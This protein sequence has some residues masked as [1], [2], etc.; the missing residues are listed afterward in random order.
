MSHNKQFTAITTRK[1]FKIATMKND[2]VN[3]K[4]KCTLQFPICYFPMELSEL[5]LKE[6]AIFFHISYFLL[7]L[8]V[9]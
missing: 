3:I 5:Y 7:R 8:D 4:C 6:K 1:N 9:L 2:K